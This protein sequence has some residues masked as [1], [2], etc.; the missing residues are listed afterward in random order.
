MPRVYLKAYCDRTQADFSHSQTNY[1][2]QATPWYLLS[3]PTVLLYPEL[4][5]FVFFNSWIIFQCKGFLSVKMG[6][7]RQSYGFDNMVEEKNDFGSRKSGGIYVSS[8][9]IVIYILVSIL[10]AA[11]VGL[12]VHFAVPERTCINDCSQCRMEVRTTP[13]PEPTTPTQTDV[14]WDTCVNMSWTRD[15]CKLL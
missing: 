12:I 1:K 15:E 7:K 11:A 4:I 10:L 9:C 8:G 14:S 5:R 6:G 2:F 3:L 13:D